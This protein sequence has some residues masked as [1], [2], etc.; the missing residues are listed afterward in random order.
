MNAMVEDKNNRS[1]SHWLTT[2][3]KG[4]LHADLSK[5]LENLVAKLH[6][7]REGGI[8]EPTASITVKLNFKLE[9][10]MVIVSPKYDVK[11]PE[12]PRDKSYY[13]VTPENRLSRHDPDQR[14]F[15]FRD[16]NSEKSDVRNA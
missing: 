2:L 16:V 7:L 13:F 15:E 8:S 4:H 1:F 9:K 5:E 3:E 10:R 11:L 12:L 14:D 6:D